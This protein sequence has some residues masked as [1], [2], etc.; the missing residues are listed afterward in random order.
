MTRK[1]ARNSQ[2][3]AQLDQ[4]LTIQRARPAVLRD[5]DGCD[6]AGW[7]DEGEM[8]PGRQVDA[9]GEG[10]RRAAGGLTLSE[11]EVHAGGLCRVVAHFEPKPIACRER[12]RGGQGQDEEE[13]SD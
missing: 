6:F 11:L 8:S 12:R 2:F 9:I 13:L 3:A 10:P 1:A 4:F 7:A 5:R